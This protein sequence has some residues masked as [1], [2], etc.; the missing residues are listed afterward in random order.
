[1]PHLLDTH[2]HF[3]F[4][5]GPERRAEFVRELARLSDAGTGDA[6]VS[7]VAQSVTPRGFVQLREQLTEIAERAGVPAEHRAVPV[8]SLGFHPW[9]ITSREQAECELEVFEGVVAS[10]LT[11]FIG[12]IGLD[13]SSR[14]LER[15]SA[16]LQKWVL[17]QVIDAVCSAAHDSADP[18]VLSVHAVQAAS[19]VLDLLKDCGL[20]DSHVVPIFHWFSGTSDELTRLMRCGGYVSINRRMLETKR[21]RAYAQQVPEERL[22]LETDLPDGGSLGAGAFVDTL[23]GTLTRLSEVCG[24]DMLPIILENQG[25]LYGTS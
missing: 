16:E 19:A 10:G 21:G 6:G 4:L 1:M 11:R 20:G 2:F 18:F 22:L 3:D 12:E 8:P 9:W 15:S 14:R 23:T 25:R 24:R 5:D 7:V 17:R 13:F